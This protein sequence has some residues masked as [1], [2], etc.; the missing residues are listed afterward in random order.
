MASS[1]A[2]AHK[3]KYDVFL[4]FRGTDTRNT[5]TSHLYEAMRRKKI[6]TFIDDGLERGEEITPALLKT[7][8]ESRMSVVIFS[9]NY[10]SSPWCLDELV[11]ILEC[12]ETYG[13]IVLPVFYHVDPS[14]V[15]EQTGSFGN[16]FA[17]LEIFFK[18]KMDKVP[19]WRAA[20]TSAAN[21]SGWDSQVTRP[22]SRLVEQIVLHIL[23]KLNY[24]SSSDL[25]GLVGMDS[26]MKQIEALL[27]TQLPEVCFVGI[28][29]MGGSGKTTIAGEIFNK[30][31]REYEGHYFLANV[32]E[33]EKNGGLFRMRDELFSKITEE[34]N[35]LIRTPRIG[36]PFIKDRICRKKVLIV[37]DDVNDVD[38]IEMLL[39][40]CDLFG[41][42][43]RIILTSRD[44]QVLKKYADKIYKVEGLNYREALHLFSLH[45]FKDNQLPYNYMELSVRAINYAKGNPLA[46]KVLGSFLFGRT[47]KEWESALNKDEKLTRQKVHSVLRISY[48][49]L[50]SD[51]KSIFLDIACFFRG[52]R[53]DFVKRI[54]DGCGFK[55]D[56][57]FS[58]L[59]DRCLIKISDDKVEMH[60]LLQEMAREVVRKES[61]DELGRQ[62][63]LWNPK[64]AYQ[65]LTNNLGTGKVEGI[66]LDVSKLRT[67]NVE[68][69]FLNVSEIREIE[70]SS[71]A[72]ARLYNLRLL[73]IYNSVAGDKC[74]VH[75]PSGLESLSHELRYLHWDG[76]PSTSLPC[77][78]RPQ[79]LVELNLSSSK[80]K[81]LWRG[82]QNLVNLKD[83]NLSNCEH[84]TSLPDLSKARNLERLNL[85]FCT[86][87]VK[88]PSSIQH[89]DR[90]ND[91]DLRGCTSLIN[92][93]SRINSRCLKSLNLSGC[94]N[95]KKCPETARKL[96][97][98][99]LNETAVEEL[100]QSIGE[101]SGLVAL[102]LKNCKHLV[103]LPE[104]IYLLKSLLIADFSGCSSISRLPDFSRN[105][106]YLYLNGTAI[107]ELPS[108]IGDLR[109]LIYLDLSG[110]SSI[111]EFPKVSNN[112]KELY[113]DGTAIREIPS[114]IECLFELAE[115]HL[116]NCKQFEI[117]PSSICKLRK[118]R[119]LNLSGCL[120]FRNFPEV[121]EP[122][123]CL[124]YLYLE[125]TSITKLPSPI[126]NLMGLAC[127]EVGNCKYLED[128]ECLRR[129]SLNGLHKLSLDGC[130]ISVLP[131][132]LGCLRSLE[133]LDLSGNDFKTIPININVL[134]ELQYLG[135][136]NCKRLESLPE[137]PPGL[138]KLDADN[139]ESLNYLESS[140]STV[141]KGNIFE[142]I[143]TNCLS[144][145][146]IN[147]I[148]PYSLMKFQLYTKRLHQLPDVPEG[149]CSFCLPGGVSPQWLSHQSWGSTVTCQLSS[150]WVNS[151][152][153]GFSLCAVIAFHSFSHSLQVK[154]TY[155]FSNEQGDSHDLY[156]YLHGWYDEKLIDS[157]HIIIGFDP[158]L[159]AKEDYVFS[160]Y[161]K[162][163]VEF[164]L[165]DMN[166]N[167][168][169]LDLCQV[170]EC[171][172][173]LLYEDGIHCI[174]Y[175][176][177]ALEAMFQGK[178]AR[179]QGKRARFQGSCWEDY[180]GMSVM[181]S[182]LANSLDFQLYPEELYRQEEPDV[183]ALPS[184]FWISGDTTPEWFSHQSWGSTVTFQLSSN[185]AN[186][187]FLG[188]S[189][190]AVIAFGPA[191][192]S[193]GSV[194]HRLPVKCTYHF[195]NKHG[196]SR[197]LDCY[198]LGKSY[199]IFCIKYGDSLDFNYNYWYL[200]K[201]QIFLGFD[202][203]LVAKE[204]D[205]FSEYSEVSVEFHLENNLF[206]FCHVVEC[207]VHLLYDSG[208]FGLCHNDED[209]LHRFH[210]IMSDSSRF[211]PL[212]RDELEGRFQAKRARFQAIRW[213]DYYV[214]HRAY[215]F[216]ADLQVTARAS[217]FCL[218]R[219]VTPEWFSHKSW[220]S[221]VTCQLS[222]HWANSEFLGFYLC[223]VI[224]FHSFKHSLQVKCTYHFRN[225]HGDS[226]DLYCDIYGWNDERRICSERM[227][228]RI[229]PCLVV[230]END[231]FSKY[232]EVSVEFQPEDM[233]GILLPLDFCQVRECGVRLLDAKD[234]H[235][236]EKRLRIK[237]GRKP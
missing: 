203:C 144:L 157:D 73:K 4:S 8:E 196:D 18:G 86:S 168:L 118:L 186:N 219:S 202:P 31:A 198:L 164:Q 221:T 131:D 84:I 199:E 65:V 176:C 222:S 156:C 215:E 70:L 13:Q 48:E 41:P 158:C 184:S 38:Q 223:A 214:M 39:G 166:G 96:T 140:S 159:V 60:D 208:A 33:S 172:V 139:C 142:F 62:S 237:K 72:F 173:R 69:M 79:N 126:G 49:A 15:D 85:Q 121:L 229:D 10:A 24:A 99:N 3:W 94:S 37:F 57:G 102:N 160:E 185:W 66:F 109:E 23:K 14:D 174:D 77:N 194:R 110:C 211:N 97:Y 105:I 114:S 132:S 119:R 212:D 59:I 182:K 220:G 51:E 217:S 145:C 197:D 154:C 177:D 75:L 147:Q 135:L 45:A 148:L 162:V 200:E 125:Q 165:E 228:V 163:S 188:F 22:E 146:R 133:V 111:T 171:G 64:D 5:F 236:L 2:V 74:T 113:L 179:F 28:W 50:D 192:L 107:E 67:E 187:E 88:V 201:E 20:L 225:E 25:K 233:N 213:E 134:F 52:H 151:E 180:I 63:R 224:A 43:S 218:P 98:L 190:C 104:N 80:V 210:L 116:R 108:S 136:R 231:M 68:G 189:L 91:L 137:L 226:H 90:L 152:F 232:S 127:L 206:R 40:G 161:S 204:K 19:R 155:H 181:F 101:Q 167:L 35:L 153:L 205:T 53:V 34:E 95:L 93:P 216:L 123:V 42:G 56:I 227:F 87:L 112:I 61:L 58:V 207:G 36:H 54:L 26:R 234:K 44:K 120:Q 143:F 81:Q 1:S 122:M 47:T 128:I 141:V 17:E 100:P 71:T 30:I 115:L 129:P 21:I 193:F 6:K 124:G 83:V 117:L 32:R 170:H 183:P 29:G 150:H 138:S 191:D 92:L 7:I 76:Y 12:K 130:H 178:R 82:D 195:R 103:N 46:L 27:C 175:Y 89:L 235:R 106:S 209:K 169:P 149:A 230:K 11:R 78:F 9:E 16:A 55:T